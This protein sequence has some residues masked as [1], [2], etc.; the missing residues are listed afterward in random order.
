MA[1]AYQ[2][3]L[4][5]KY[6]RPT[7]IQDNINTVTVMTFLEDASPA[8]VREFTKSIETNFSS[9]L[10]FTNALEEAAKISDK[11][12]YET[13]SLRASSKRVYESLVDLAAFLGPMAK[14]R[15]FISMI[16]HGM[17]STF[18]VGW[19][20]P[21]AG[22]VVWDR[23]TQA[24]EDPVM[25]FASVAQAFASWNYQC[26]AKPRDPVEPPLYRYHP[27]RFKASRGYADAV[28]KL[29]RQKVEP[30]SG[31]LTLDQ[32]NE[33]MSLLVKDLSARSMRYPRKLKDDH[34]SPSLVLDAEQVLSMS[35]GRFV[36]AGR[37]IMEF[38]DQLIALLAQ[39]DIDD[40][41][42]ESI[43]L[44]YA[45]QYL[46]F[47]PQASLELE[48]GWLVDGAYVE[49]RGAN[50]D[51]RFTITA[52]PI[53][54]GQVQNW[55]L[56]PEPTYTQ[57]FIERYRSMDLGTAIDS[58][59]A[60][61]LANLSSR[62]TDAVSR[63]PASGMNAN[64]TGGIVPPNVEVQ[65]VSAELALSREE[66]T[67]RRHPVYKA[68]LQLVVNAL[69]YVAAYPDD[70]DAV[71][72]IGTPAPL[73]DKAV[74]GQGKEVIKAKSK[75]SALGYVPVHICG[76]ALSDQ[77]AAQ[78]QSGLMPD[79]PSTHWRRGHW[80][81]QAFGPARTLR[82]LIWVMPVMVGAKNSQEPEFGHLYLVS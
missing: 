74:H 22:Q 78:Q 20:D 1:H 28:G 47:G 44:P 55:Y 70:M 30:I 43:R 15:N 82:K 29:Y 4:L 53:D 38:P 18:E 71:W 16:N 25:A 77:L 26:G 21:R 67:R 69:C 51:L 57:D 14:E 56:F 31:L 52:S 36:Q 17:E 80:R 46:S 66:S 13:E 41:A 61:K 34:P 39:T 8:T 60:E 2:P 24:T 40:I 72:P 9:V 35:Y 50:G 75:L 73:R 32:M 54:R 3:R 68:A 49:Q 76:K 63:K 27:E 79:G 6:N 45:C 65:D 11:V 19:S 59:L 7:T 48:D 12:L 33:G 5:V 81:N 58:V 62:M 23:W 64:Q 10:R 37:Q 42:L